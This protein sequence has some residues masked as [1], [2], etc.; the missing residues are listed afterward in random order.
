MWKD[1]IIEEIRQARFDIETE[2][3]NDFNKIFADAARVQKD[4]INRVVSKPASNTSEI[5]R[6]DELVTV[7]DT[8]GA[9]HY[10]TLS[11]DPIEMILHVMDA[12]GLS[13]RDL[14]PFL[15]SRARVSEVLNRHRP[16]SLE[17]IR[18]LHIGLNIPADVLIKPYELHRPQQSGAETFETA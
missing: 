18:K 3:D 2:C 8:Y 13:Q 11:P 16:L 15:G 14:E 17:M 9:E 4:L 6:L 7:V 1:P 10:T 5:D 12:R